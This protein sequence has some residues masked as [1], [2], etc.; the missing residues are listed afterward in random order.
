MPQHLFPLFRFLLLRDIPSHRRRCATTSYCVR[1]VHSKTAALS[2]DALPRRRC[3]HNMRT[4]RFHPLSS[5]RGRLRLISARRMYV[6]MGGVLVAGGT[7][8]CSAWVMRRVDLSE[9]LEVPY[10]EFH[11]CW[12]R[13]WRLTQPPSSARSHLTQPHFM[14]FLSPTPSPPMSSLRANETIGRRL[15]A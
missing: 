13:P 15:F 14:A 2:T 8:A 7:L 1:Y 3:D 9:V 11:C 12:L 5:P 4:S 6:M 10:G